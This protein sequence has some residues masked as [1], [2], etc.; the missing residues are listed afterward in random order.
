ML[1]AYQ[2]SAR[3]QYPEFSGSRSFKTAL[4]LPPTFCRSAP[5]SEAS[6]NILPETG[7]VRASRLCF[8]AGAKNASSSAARK[9]FVPHHAAR[10]PAQLAS[11][12]SSGSRREVRTE[13]LH[14]P[15]TLAASREPMEFRSYGLYAAVSENEAATPFG[16]S[17]HC[18]TGCK[19][20]ISRD[21]R[22]GCR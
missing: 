16:E 18:S 17:E 3:T 19:Q 21:C 8:R 4:S 9:K 2:K 22:R 1:K 10:R 7:G 13:C 5:R 20:A 6:T 15:S 14:S 12:A 11:F